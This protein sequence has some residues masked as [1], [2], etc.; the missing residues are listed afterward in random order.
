MRRPERSVWFGERDR[1]AYSLLGEPNGD[2]DLRSK[3]TECPSQPVIILS[4]IFLYAHKNA[5][6]SLRILSERWKQ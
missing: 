5:N 1:T 2:N 3:S 4:T 6:K